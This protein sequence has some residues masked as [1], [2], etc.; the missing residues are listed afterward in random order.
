[1]RRFLQFFLLLAAIAGAAF[2]VVRG[3]RPPVENPDARLQVAS[4]TTGDLTRDVRIVGTVTQQWKVPLQVNRGYSSVVAMRE[5]AHRFLR[6]S[7]EGK[8]CIIGYF[9]DHDPSGEDM[10]RDIRDRLS[11]FHADLTVKKLAILQ[12][13]IQEY[14]L[15]PQPVK[16]TDARAASFRMA[17]GDDCVELDALRPDVLS[18][19]VQDFISDHLD[20]DLWN[21]VREEERRQRESVRVE[22]D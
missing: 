8:E 20:M 11:T 1:M 10:V 2:Y 6:A 14:N 21:Q 12:D 7:D 3:L 9:G 22:T 13:D 18:G 4:V 17:H 16:D 19:R 15:P 5:A